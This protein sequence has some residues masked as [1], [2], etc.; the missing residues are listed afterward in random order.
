MN[1]DSARL[2][3]KWKKKNNLFLKL[4]QVQPAIIYTCTNWFRS[5]ISGRQP[6]FSVTQKISDT[7]GVYL[8]PLT[9]KTDD[10]MKSVLLILFSDDMTYRVLQSTAKKK[11]FFHKILPLSNN[12]FNKL[13]IVNYFSFSSFLFF[14]DGTIANDTSRF[15]CF[16]ETKFRKIHRNSCIDTFYTWKNCD[17]ELILTY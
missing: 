14:V 5:E 1:I 3:T 16:S 6:Q 9:D 4:L 7:F 12:H 2:T 11:S 17:H 13:N 15:K 10:V 8:C